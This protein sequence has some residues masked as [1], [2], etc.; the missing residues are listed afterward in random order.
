V[1]RA[2]T[3]SFVAFAPALVVALVATFIVAPTRTRAVDPDVD[4][5]TAW[6]H[7]ARVQ[8]NRVE[9]SEVPSKIA[10][11]MLAILQK[12]ARPCDCRARRLRWVWA[13]PRPQDRGEHPALVVA[14]DDRPR[15]EGPLLR[16]ERY[17][18]LSYRDGAYRVGQVLSLRRP[19]P[20]S[21]ARLHV[22][23]RPRRDLDFDGQL[24]LAL[25]V[26]EHWTERDRYCAEARFLS[27]APELKVEERACEGTFADDNGHGRRRARQLKDS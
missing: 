5:F 17:A 16:Y 20:N 12:G 4:P 13:L 15:A 19:A 7:E 3:S 23:L 26:D 1:P 24:D 18:L 27:A 25:R 22:A 8:R 14:F 10:E 21:S 2:P 6:T 9:G 11:Q